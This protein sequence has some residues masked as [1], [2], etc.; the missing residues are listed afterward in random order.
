MNRFT[1]IADKQISM[2]RKG[3]PPSV[4][5]DELIQKI[6]EE[7]VKEIISQFRNFQT[8]FPKFPEQFYIS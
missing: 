1:L 3:W 8:N 2:K 7:A 4:A 5:T 6:M